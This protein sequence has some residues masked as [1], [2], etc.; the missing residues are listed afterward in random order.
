[1]LTL[2]AAGLLLELGQ[3]VQ[4]NFEFF[5]ALK[6]VVLGL[7]LEHGE[8]VAFAPQ[9][10]VLFHEVVEDFQETGAVLYHFTEYF[11]EI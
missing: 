9:R 6:M 7:D 10:L 1:L 8:L 2:F 11:L 4:S 5:L 3:L